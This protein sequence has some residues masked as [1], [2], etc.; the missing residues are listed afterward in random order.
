MTD[1]IARYREWF[2]AAVEKHVV[3]PKAAC[4]STADAAGRPSGR[5]V[6]IQYADS[7]GLAFFTNFQSRKARELDARPVA[8]LCVF[9]REIDRQVRFEG[10]IARLPHQESD[11]YFATRPRE[12]QLGAWASQQSEIL[13]SRDELERRLA[14][15]EH[16]FDGTTV[17]RPPFWG[18]YR[19]VPNRVEFWSGRTGRLHDRELFEREGSAWRRCLLYP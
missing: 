15:V 11:T 4:L 1:P 13:A 5:M 19:L 10:E 16:R 6:L 7:R 14:D 18:G 3:E 17:T 12:S 9:W 2:A 8:S